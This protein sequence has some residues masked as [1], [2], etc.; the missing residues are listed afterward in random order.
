[1]HCLLA[2]LPGLLLVVLLCLLSLLVLGKEA[3]RATG[4]FREG[5]PEEGLQG[6]GRGGTP[7]AMRGQDS[8]GV[9]EQPPWPLGVLGS[10]TQGCA[11][12]ACPGFL[13]TLVSWSLLCHDCSRDISYHLYHFKVFQMLCLVPS[14]L[15]PAIFSSFAGFSRLTQNVTQST[16]L[17]FLRMT[18]PLVFLFSIFCQICFLEMG[19]KEL[20]LIKDTRLRNPDLKK[21]STSFF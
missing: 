18:D 2:L 8:P 11:L 20:L 5:L 12:G 13:H 15:F 1:M 6:Q 21:L 10:L 17:F 16:T 9:P 4:T 7:P 3:R 14:K 19:A